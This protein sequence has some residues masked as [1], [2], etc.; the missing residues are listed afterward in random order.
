MTKKLQIPQGTTATPEWV[1]AVRDIIE[2]LTGKRNNKI[3][4]PTIQALTFSSPPTQAEL[5]AFFA[6]QQTWNEALQSIVTRFDG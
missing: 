6:Y 4:V 2:I 3:K 1:R 5:N